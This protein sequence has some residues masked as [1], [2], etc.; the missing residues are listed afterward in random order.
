MKRVHTPTVFTVA[1][2]LLFAGALAAENGG[3][4]PHSVPRVNS[5]IKVDGILEEPVWGGTIKTATAMRRAAVI[6]IIGF[7]RSPWQNAAPGRS[8]MWRRKRP[9]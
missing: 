4:P 7:S 5:D 9:G 8:F 3:K 6:P 1:A 2:L